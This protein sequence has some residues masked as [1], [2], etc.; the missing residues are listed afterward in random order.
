MKVNSINSPQKNVLIKRN[1]HLDAWLHFVQLAK[2]LL[3][4]IQHKQ[5]GCGNLQLGGFYESL[6]M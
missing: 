6:G 1:A 5:L 3:M 4:N 2:V